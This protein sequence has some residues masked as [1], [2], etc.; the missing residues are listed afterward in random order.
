VCL[1]LQLSCLFR[2]HFVASGQVSTNHQPR[3]KENVIT[4]RHTGL[5]PRN[6][7]IVP[8]SWN[9]LPFLQL[10]QTFSLQGPKKFRNRSGS[11]LEKKSPEY[12]AT[13]LKYSRNEG[14]VSFLNNQDSQFSL[15]R[16][17][18]VPRTSLP[19]IR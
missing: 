7:H 10:F 19:Q 13:S 9:A 1:S 12:T 3:S 11:K 14:L 5:H 6:E 2:E 15:E 18:L 17:H 16:E 8:F 4:F